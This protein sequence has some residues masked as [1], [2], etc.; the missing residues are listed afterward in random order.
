MKPLTVPTLFVIRESFWIA[1]EAAQLRGFFFGANITLW[2]RISILPHGYQQ[3]SR[4]TEA[5]MGMQRRFS[6]R[7]N[8][9]GTLLIESIYVTVGVSLLLGR[10]ISHQVAIN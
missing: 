5:L 3:M 9:N 7:R 4:R 6:G 10:D 8:W 1:S 2:G